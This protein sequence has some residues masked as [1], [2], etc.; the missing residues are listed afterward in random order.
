MDEDDSHLQDIVSIEDISLSLSDIERIAHDEAYLREYQRKLTSDIYSKIMLALTHE[1]FSEL[2]ARRLWLG[3]CQ[4]LHTLNTTLGRNVGI[5]VAALD[6][7]TNINPQLD[8]ALLIQEHKSDYITDSS[9]KDELTGLYQRRVFDVVLKKEYEQSRRVD[10]PMSLIL[11]DIDDFKRI[12]DTYGHVEGDRVLAEIGKTIN[13]HLREMDIAA[14]YGG[15]ELAIIMPNSSAERAFYAAERLR[16]R[17][18][19]LQF[20]DYSVTVSMGIGC[21]CADVETL[22]DI[23]SRADEALYEAKA[24]GKNRVVVAD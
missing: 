15:E 11:I 1:S 3:I 2:E 14:R 5:S 16:R 23:F 8:S 20:S 7:L 21:L 22:E 19:R 17:I 12:N 4:H 24:H 9:T 10:I 13:K 18:S 6:Y